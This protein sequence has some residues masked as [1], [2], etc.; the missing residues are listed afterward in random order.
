MTDA[1]LTVRRVVTGHDEHGKSIILS[2]GPWPQFSDRAMFAEVW[3]TEGSPARITAVEQREPNNRPAQLAP[4]PGGSIIRVVEMGAA[5]RS[6]MH[7]T[8]PS[9][10]ASCWR[11]KSSS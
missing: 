5:H 9:I 7:R 10:T 3:N 11:E 8:R 4:P 2:D 6:P 1:R